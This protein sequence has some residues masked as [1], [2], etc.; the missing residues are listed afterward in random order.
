MPL[1]AEAA[2]AHPEVE[3]LFVNQGDL[4][5]VAAKLPAQHGIDPATVL[6]DQGARLSATYGGALPSTIFVGPAGEVRSVHAGEISRA[7][8]SDK[9]N[10]IKEARP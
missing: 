1:L 5:D 3:F 7:A 2:R 9:I 10:L 6:L 4:A 8:L